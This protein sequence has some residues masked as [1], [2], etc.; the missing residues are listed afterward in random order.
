MDNTIIASLIGVAGTIIAAIIAVVV[1]R[2]KKPNLQLVDAVVLVPSKIAQTSAKPD[3]LEYHTIEPKLH[4]PYRTDALGKGHFFPIVDL[5]FVNSG[6]GV[7]FLKRMQVDVSG[8]TVDPTPIL[9][10]GIESDVDGNLVIKVKN[11]GWGPALSVKLNNLQHEGLRKHLSLN[12][13]EYL[14]E[15]EIPPEGTIAI[16]FPCSS[17]MGDSEAEVREPGG[18]IVYRDLLNNEYGRTIRYESYIFEEY[19]V[20]IKDR[21]FR[22]ERHD[23]ANAKK[24]SCRHTVML[25]AAPKQYSKTYNISMEVGA[26]E[27]ERFQVILAAEKSATFTVSF[28]IHY[29][30]NRAVQTTPL[31]LRV[32]NPN[33]LWYYNYLKEPALGKDTLEKLCLDGSE[34]IPDENNKDEKNDFE[35]SESAAWAF[36]DIAWVLIDQEINVA[37][38]L[39][40]ADKALVMKADEPFILDTIGW[41]YYRMRH[42]NKAMDFFERA[43]RK[44]PEDKLIKEHFKIVSSIIKK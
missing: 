28:I 7:A 40:L 42:Y 17:I 8:M 15:G 12:G 41:G 22:I 35:N 18:Y 21:R 10:F 13:R 37:E 1:R 38:G 34:I 20:K 6:D 27:T 3:R 33:S 16:K 29:N 25:P 4:F 5:K 30:D 32:W 2:R 14:W 26:N 23:Y 36:N 24:V 19:R 31:K 11:C 9:E 44:A 43:I 39:R